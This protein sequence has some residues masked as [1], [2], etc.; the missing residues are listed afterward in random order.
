MMVDQDSPWKPPSLRRRR[1][2][3]DLVYVIVEEEIDGTMGLVV[4]EWPDGGHGGPRFDEKAE[5]ELAVDREALQRHLAE[6]R[7]PAQPEMSE[8]AIAELRNRRVASGD[9]FAVEPAEPLS[10]ETDPDQLR[11]CGWIGEAI[12]ITADAREAAK[13]KMYEALTS[14]LGTDLAKR[15]LAEERETEPG[16]ATA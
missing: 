7:M 9:V 3:E 12:D 15:L 2:F 1:D 6:R 13:A 16:E 5:F 8:E 14:P 4:A 11:S 10:P